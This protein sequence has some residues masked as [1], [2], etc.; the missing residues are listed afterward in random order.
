MFSKTSLAL[1]NNPCDATR[2][3]INNCGFLVGCVTCNVPVVI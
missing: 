2:Y 3:I 1:L